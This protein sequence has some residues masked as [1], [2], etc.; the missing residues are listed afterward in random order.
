MVSTLSLPCACVELGL[1]I[2]Y[3]FAIGVTNL[4]PFWAHLEFASL[5]GLIYSISPSLEVQLE[6]LPVRARTHTRVADH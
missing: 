5:S 2:N 4:S 6:P 3:H 1:K